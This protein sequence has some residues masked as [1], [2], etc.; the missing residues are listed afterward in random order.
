MF[1]TK[2]MDIDKSQIQAVIALDVKRTVCHQ[3]TTHCDGL[4]KIL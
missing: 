2:L 4:E 1:T 3:E